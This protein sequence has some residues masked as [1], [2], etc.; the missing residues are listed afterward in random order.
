M[1]RPNIL[2]GLSL[3]LALLS[4]GCDTL[5]VER[6]VTMRL[7]PNSDDFWDLPLPSDLRKKADGSYGLSNWPEIK[8]NDYIDMW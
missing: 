5:H 1:R 2:V 4:T 8:S 7:T 3:I 6:D